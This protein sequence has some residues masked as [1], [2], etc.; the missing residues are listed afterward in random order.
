ML[1]LLMSPLSRH[2][3]FRLTTST[4]C[5]VTKTEISPE[6][7]TTPSRLV[8]SILAGLYTLMLQEILPRRSLLAVRIVDK[9]RKGSWF[10]H[11]HC[12]P[13][14][15]DSDEL[16]S[17]T[18]SVAIFA[19]ASISSKIDFFLLSSPPTPFSPSKNYRGSAATR[20]ASGRDD[21]MHSRPMRR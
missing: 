18:T 13:F 21:V 5:P 14:R 16:C 20:G 2:K 15:S 11:S 4:I 10:S 9:G 1:K 19:Q 3:Y 7:I 8:L 12:L 6:T 17:Q